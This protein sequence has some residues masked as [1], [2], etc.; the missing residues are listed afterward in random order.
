MT[1]HCTIKPMTCDHHL[2]AT[3]WWMAHCPKDDRLIL[4][5]SLPRFH[6]PSV[7]LFFFF[8][9]GIE[10]NL[11]QIQIGVFQILDARLSFV[12]MRQKAEDKNI[13]IWHPQFEKGQVGGGGSDP[14]HVQ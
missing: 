1:L 3:V 13:D 11:A 12:H 2:V 8:K 5:S 10:G 7:H 6:A 14:T 4:D 9:G